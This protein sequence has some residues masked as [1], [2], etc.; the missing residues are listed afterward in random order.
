MEKVKQVTE[1]HARA[2]AYA[3][4]GG[5]KI[6][7]GTDPVLPGMHGRNYMELVALMS[8]G[9]SALSAWHSGTGLA[10]AG[11]GQDDTGTLRPG[12]RADLLVCSENVIDDPSALD[13]G[14]LLEVVKDGVGYRDGLPE[15]PQRTYR[16]DLAGQLNPEDMRP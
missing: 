5:L 11:I 16:E 3:H 10:A 1:V 12:Q 4:T 8:E 6:L 2:T 13:R 15:L 9:M 14:A 7:A